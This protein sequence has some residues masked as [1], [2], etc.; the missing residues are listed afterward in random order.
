M[1]CSVPGA[2]LLPPPGSPLILLPKELSGK[3]GDHVRRPC[4]LSLAEQAP[5]RDGHWV[6]RIHLCDTCYLFFPSAKFTVRIQDPS[7]R[8]ALRFRQ[9]KKWPRSVWDI[10]LPS[11]VSEG[12]YSQSPSEEN[13]SLSAIRSLLRSS[14]VQYVSKDAQ[15]IGDSTW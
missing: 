7:R 5:L 6:C 9:W 10:S 15:H 12:K 1:F 3:R 14:S 11:R 8:G 2:L 4:T 13:R